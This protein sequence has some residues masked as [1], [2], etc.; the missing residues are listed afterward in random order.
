MPDVRTQTARR[1]RAVREWWNDALAALTPGQQATIVAALTLAFVLVAFGQPR[2]TQAGPIG[3]LGSAPL[4]TDSSHAGSQSTTT[5]AT[6]SPPI[7]PPAASIS[8]A[9]DTPAA[10]GPVIDP[11]A[12]VPSPAA[13]EEP[14][15]TTTAPSPPSSSPPTTS[16][17]PLPLP[18][19]SAP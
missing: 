14:A 3:G 8:P 17:L 12:T 7:A 19:P 15:T 2:H 16:L 11:L 9:P 10:P 18:I 13:P 6:T 1:W 4:T 5:T